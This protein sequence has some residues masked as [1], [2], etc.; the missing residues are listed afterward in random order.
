MVGEGTGACRG[1]YGENV[2][3]KA[4]LYRPARVPYG[5]AGSAEP[6]FGRCAHMV[7]AVGIS[8]VDII[9][10]MDGFKE[11]EGSYHCDRLITE[12]GGMAATAV[13]AAAR[14]G[15]ETRLFSRVGDDVHGRFVVEGLRAFGV[16]TSGVVTVP[17]RTT[18]T[19][20]VFVDRNTGEK[21]FYS[22]FE[23]SAYIEP[24]EADLSPLEK[25]DVLLVDGHWMDQALRSARW[26]RERGVPVVADFKYMYD[27]LAEVFPYV[28]YLIIPLFF[29]AE[30]TGER[31]IERILETL[32]SRFWGT[33]VVTLGGEG[34][35]Y[36]SDGALRRYRTFPVACVD[37]TGAGDAF[38]GAFC[39]F[40]SRGADLSRCLELS[41]AVGALN[42]R[43]LGGR[44]ALP[45]P[46]ELSAF[47]T[48]NGTDPRLP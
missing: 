37:S 29:A 40:L 48:L 26:A 17:G 22:E 43:A 20:I 45:T 24:V 27:G 10:V 4:C 46:E 25:M 39:H 2:P 41:S 42:C 5:F 7:A 36:L 38:H 35:A 15:S 47:L 14:L 34:G 16:D 13:C 9:L 33:S 12:G 23:K 8:V 18:M 19:S 6:I 3:Q 28:D 32:E 44:A 11:G 31:S 30:I 1:N 21:Q